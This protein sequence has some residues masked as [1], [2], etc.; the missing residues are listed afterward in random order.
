MRKKLKQTHNQANKKQRP[1]VQ[2]VSS[3]VE[4]PHGRLVTENTNYIASVATMDGGAYAKTKVSA[5]YVV[6]EDI[7]THLELP[8]QTNQKHFSKSFQLF[9]RLHYMLSFYFPSFYK[10]YII[11]KV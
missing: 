5:L 1:S 2:V 11:N 8:H 10:S 7:L 9:C 3:P 4:K 6:V